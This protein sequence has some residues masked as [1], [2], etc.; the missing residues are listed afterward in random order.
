VLRG[1][2][3]A[4]IDDSGRLKLPA[5]FRRAIEETWGRALY[6]TS[7]EGECLWVYPLPIWTRKEA[8]LLGRSSQLKA[9]AKFLARVSYYGAEVELDRQGRVLVPNPVRTAAGIDG[10]VAVLGALDHLVVWNNA[11]FKSRLE[12]EPITDEDRRVLA[13]LGV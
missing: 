13:D 3:L 7:L 1:N 2:A 8:L 12:A 11:A 10:E 4:T 6:L 5:D 9:V